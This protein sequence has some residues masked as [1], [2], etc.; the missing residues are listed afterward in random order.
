MYVALA[1]EPPEMMFKSWISVFLSQSPMNCWSRRGRILLCAYPLC[2]RAK[3]QKGRY[4]QFL[5]KLYWGAGRRTRANELSACP[6]EF[7]ADGGARP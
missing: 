3:I 4:S 6:F 2:G 7:T 5:G 1:A